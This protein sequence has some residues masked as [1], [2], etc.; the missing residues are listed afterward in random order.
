M[1]FPPVVDLLVG[2]Q[3][4]TVALSTLRKFPGSMLSKMFAGNVGV[5]VKDGAYF[6]DRSAEFFGTILEYLRDGD[7]ELPQDSVQLRRLLREANFFGLDGLVEKTEEQLQMISIHVAL[8]DGAYNCTDQ[9]CNCG[10]GK[11]VMQYVDESRSYEVRHPP[12]DR[13]KP[14]TSPFVTLDV[15]VRHADGKVQGVD[16]AHAAVVTQL[17]QRYPDDTETFTERSQFL[18]KIKSKLKEI[19]SRPEISQSMLE[20]SAT[21]Y[22]LGSEIY[23]HDHER[24]EH[25]RSW[26]VIVFSRQFAEERP[27]RK[28]RIL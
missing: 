28:S 17:R 26:L 20:G 13:P 12:P 2:G 14:L 4:F 19:A 3:R 6:I 24:E 9:E 10:V 23:D 25:L 8:H 18:G 15:V 27:S 7:V 22:L 11:S 21:P 16:E 5:L 1:E